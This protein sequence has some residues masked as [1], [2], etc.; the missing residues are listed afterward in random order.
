MVTSGFACHQGKIAQEIQDCLPSDS[1]TSPFLP[2]LDTASQ[3]LLRASAL[4]ILCRVTLLSHDRILLQMAVGVQQVKCLHIIFY[5]PGYH[6]HTQNVGK[7]VIKRPTLFCR[8]WSSSTLVSLVLKLT[9]FLKCQGWYIY[10]SAILFISYQ[11][12][13]YTN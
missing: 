3:D 10:S 12:W 8:S 6:G 13:F 5:I 4:F 9:L 11:R 7:H 1:S 2:E